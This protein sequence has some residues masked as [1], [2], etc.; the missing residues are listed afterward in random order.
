MSFAPT[1]GP[2]E[3]PPS[4]SV[5][6]TPQTNSETESQLTSAQTDN[7][8]TDLIYENATV[9]VKL[10]YPSDWTNHG[11]F[12]DEFISIIAAFQGSVDKHGLPVVHILSKSNDED[13]TAKDYA[14]EFFKNEEKNVEGYNIVEIQTDGIT[15]GGKP[16]YKA[17]VTYNICIAED[18][19]GEEKRGK[20]L[21]VGT[22]NDNGKIIAIN[23]DAYESDYPKYLPIAQKMI[24]SLEVK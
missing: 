10:S 12:E 7:S 5:P 4:Q 24:D 3:N 17:V 21:E 20:M 9:G 16:A 13:K 14:N 6:S 8:S 15:I 2:T 18:C 23:Y 19:A 1:E 22:V 11:S